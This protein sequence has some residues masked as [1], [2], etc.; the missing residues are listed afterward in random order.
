[1]TRRRDLYGRLERVHER[2]P[3]P[4]GLTPEERRRR[5]R[6]ALDELIE[7]DPEGVEGMSPEEQDAFFAELYE[8][9]RERQRRDGRNP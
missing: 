9:I 5:V 7:N 8:N 1:V 4:N 2:M 6:E 3:T